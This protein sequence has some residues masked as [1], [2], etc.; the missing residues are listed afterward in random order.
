MRRDGAGALDDPCASEPGRYR[1]LA[2]RTTGGLDRGTI[3]C[4]RGKRDYAALAPQVWLLPSR[5]AFLHKQPCAMLDGTALAE[6]HKYRYANL[7]Y[8]QGR[9]DARRR[10]GSAPRV[11]AAVELETIAPDPHRVAL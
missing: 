1:G 5:Y 7:D 11:E 3:R 4:E 6:P 10:H 2:R 8:A 9:L